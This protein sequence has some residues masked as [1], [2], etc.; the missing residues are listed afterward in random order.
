VV[1]IAV[2]LAVY[3][4]SWMAIRRGKPALPWMAMA[5]LAFSLTTL[6]PVV[7]VYFDV[8]LLLAAAAIAETPWLGRHPV[9]AAWTATL[10]MSIAIVVLTAWT[11]IPIDTSIDVGS[12]RD[13]EYLYAGF[14]A[15]EQGSD[16]NYTWIDGTQAE[17]LVPRRAR[18]AA[19]IDIVCEPHLTP[20]SRVQQMSA[21]LNGTVLG[22]VTLNEGWQTVSLPAPA[23]AW[24]IGVNTLTLSLAAAVSP[25][26]SG[27]SAD[28]RRLSVAVDRLTVRAN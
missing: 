10:A 7:Y 21:S 8:F 17:I 12:A 15:D 3:A 11:M 4:T 14:S 20:S 9:G 19:M 26:E 25:F 1:Q 18:S 28:R 27:E 5:L 22:T 13:R 16:R 6:W 23:R 2:M 24:Q